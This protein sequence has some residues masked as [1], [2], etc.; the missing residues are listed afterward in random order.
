M[1]RN[2][3]FGMMVGTV[4]NEWTG[5][6]VMKYPVL[7]A[8]MVLALPGA[9][10]AGANYVRN[11]QGSFAIDPQKANEFLHHAYSDKRVADNAYDVLINKRRGNCYDAVVHLFRYYDD[12]AGNVEKYCYKPDLDSDNAVAP[13]PAVNHP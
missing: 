3:V 7:C 13:P 4:C 6:N 1:S 8:L 10:Q 12:G 11:D 2:G 9:A 5:N